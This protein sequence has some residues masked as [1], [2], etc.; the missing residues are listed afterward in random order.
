MN[1]QHDWSCVE[2][3][4]EASRLKISSYGTSLTRLQRLSQSAPKFTSII[5]HS[6]TGYLYS[7]LLA[8]SVSPS[9]MSFLLGLMISLVYLSLAIVNWIPFFLELAIT[10]SHHRNLSRQRGVGHSI[11][12]TNIVFIYLESFIHFRC[13]GSSSLFSSFNSSFLYSAVFATFT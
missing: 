1:D 12:K 5:C 11:L 4:A 8:A 7:F 6:L 10:T 2:A 13:P 3:V 9:I